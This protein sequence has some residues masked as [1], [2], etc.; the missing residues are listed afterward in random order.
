MDLMLYAYVPVSLTSC[1]RDL[2]CAEPK[3]AMPHL[4]P[5]CAGAD[6]GRLWFVTHYLLPAD[7]EWWQVNKG[8]AFS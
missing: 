8:D 5:Q 4:T 3:A 1:Q 2:L 7:G 6:H